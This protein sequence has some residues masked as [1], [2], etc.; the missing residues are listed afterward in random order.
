[1]QWR[2]Q[3]D[4]EVQTP[5][6]EKKRKKR[7]NERKKKKEKRKKKKES[8]GVRMGKRQQAVPKLMLQPFN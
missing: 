1:M 2:S 4:P 3:G 6:A 8:E 7:K 5:S